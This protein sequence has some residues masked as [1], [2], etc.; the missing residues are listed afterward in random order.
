MV[1]KRDTFLESDLFPRGAGKG[2]TP[3]V[4]KRDGEILFGPEKKRQRRPDDTDDVRLSD[5][6]KVTQNGASLIIS[7]VS[8]GMTLIALVTSANSSSI[9]LA[10]PSGLRAVA[11][12]DELLV[13]VPNT[14]THR[15]AVA[16]AIERDVS[17]SDSDNDSTTADENDDDD[18]RISP[19]WRVLSIGQTVRATV[20]DIEQNENGRKILRVSLKPELVNISMTNGSVLQKGFPVYAAVKSVEDHGY[21]LSFGP[22]IVHS[23]F[24]PFENFH[25]ASDDLSDDD[26][27]HKLRPGHPIEVVV[28]R[29][30]SLPQKRR[31]NYSAAVRVTAHPKSVLAARVEL[32][33]GLSYQQLRAGVLVKARVMDEGPGGVALKAFGLFSIAVDAAHVPRSKDGSWEVTVGKSILTRFLSVYPVQK[34]IIATLLPGLVHRNIPR[35]MPNRWRIGTIMKSLKVDNV[36]PGF[37]L[38]LSYLPYSDADENDKEAADED[39]IMEDVASLNQLMVTWS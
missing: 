24:L 4:R 23:G 17:D 34:R 35:S 7:R 6:S 36:K 33:E 28:E 18:N 25:R 8:L 3:R 21:V 29:D 19:L 38:T 9:D 13:D 27:D 2:S 37:G 39:Q 20:M 1:A 30:L 11:D 32:T 12:P 15:D 26:D 22:S 31:S 14:N 5:T 10:L 16:R